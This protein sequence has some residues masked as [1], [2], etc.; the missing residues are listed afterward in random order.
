ARPRPPATD[1]NI[2][3]LVSAIS[4]ACSTARTF[5]AVRCSIERF[6]EDD[7]ALG[8]DWMADGARASVAMR[9]GPVD[10]D[11][12]WLISW[13]VTLVDCQ[14]ARSAD[15]MAVH[16]RPHIRMGPY[17]VGRNHG[18]GLA[19]RRPQTFE[20]RDELHTTRIPCAHEIDDDFLRIPDAI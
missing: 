5:F 3:S 14:V 9:D 6:R 16:A 19:V 17:R 11:R 13:I 7:M 12:P 10:A 2:R 4:R 15:S 18:R 8:N 1:R 20:E